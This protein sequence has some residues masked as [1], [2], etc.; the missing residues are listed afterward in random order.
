MSAA[1][2]FDTERFSRQ[3]RYRPLGPEGQLRL[4]AAHV[5]VVGCGAL[6]SVSAMALARAGIGRL[7]LIDRDVPEWSNLPRQILFTEQDVREGMPKAVVAACRLREI[8][9]RLR[10]EGTVADLT[11]E[12][13]GSLCASADLIVDGTDNFETRFLINDFACRETIPWIY[14]G[15]IGAEGRVMPVVPGVTACLR[16]LIPE[17]PAPGSLPTCDTAGVIG[18]AVLVV[19]GVQAAEAI[20]LLVGTDQPLPSQL[21]V[22]DLWESS[23]RTIDLGPL[24]VGGCDSCRGGDYPWLTGAVSNEATVLCGQ[25]A[26]Q[27]RL[28]TGQTVDLE[29]LA[30][31]LSAVGSVTV[32]RWLLRAEVEQGLTLSVFADGRLIVTGTRD[33]SRGRSI[34]ARYVGL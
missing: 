28:G 27:F 24:A 4:A 8:D 17:P 26:V 31:R 21:L 20:K 16:C 19:G 30:V 3:V 18:P 13:I 14:G 1:D 9:S 11:A 2:S 29:D 23:W 10:V 22:C 7:T 15:V 12:S 5:V 32:N 34:A 25:D 33:P 6:G